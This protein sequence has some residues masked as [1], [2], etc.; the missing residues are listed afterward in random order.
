[1]PIAFIT[2]DNV[3]KDEVDYIHFKCK[4]QK[5]WNC[6]NADLFPLIKPGNRIKIDYSEGKVKPGM[7]YP[8]KY[9]NNARIATGDDPPNTWP[10]KE[11]YSGGGKSSMS[12]KDDYDPEVSKRQTAANVAG[13]YFSSQGAT[14]DDFVNSFPTVADAVYNWINQ[15]PVDTFRGDGE[16]G[17]SNSGGQEA[18]EF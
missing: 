3:D 15:K 16:E 2:V 13:A 7:K 4:S 8:P 9:I 14:V 1:M 5:A 10:D 18:I 17:D 6:K 11:P 12:K